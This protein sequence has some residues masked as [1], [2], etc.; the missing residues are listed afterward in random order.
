MLELRLL[1][2]KT[3]PEVDMWQVD[4]ETFEHFMLRLVERDKFELAKPA[5]H[6]Q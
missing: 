2:A 1:P 6:S 5:V 3:R 4:Y